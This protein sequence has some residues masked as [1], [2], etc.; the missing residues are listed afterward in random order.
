M[1][2]RLFLIQAARTNEARALT[3]ANRT[4]ANANL[5]LGS[6]HGTPK[7]NEIMNDPVL[8]KAVSGLDVGGPV[9]DV[10]A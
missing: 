1:A 7:W 2:G 3:H 9:P 6:L 4:A 10:T 8:S 5:L